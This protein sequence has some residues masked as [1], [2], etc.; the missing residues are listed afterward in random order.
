MAAIFV[1]TISSAQPII[2]TDTFPTPKETVFT[3]LGDEAQQYRFQS[4]ALNDSFDIITFDHVHSSGNIFAHDAFI[5]PINLGEEPSLIVMQNGNVRVSWGCFACGRYHSISSV[6]LSLKQDQ[7]HVIGYDHSYADR[8][9]AAVFS[10][11]VNFLTGKAIIQADDIE[12]RHLTTNETT[13]SVKNLSNVP[14]PAVC[15]ALDDYD[16]DFLEKHFDN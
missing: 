7:L 9:Y 4:F 3:S 11:S 16:H 15:D 13:Y 2:D 6:T 14:A 8:L 5:A 1:A 10:C 12:T